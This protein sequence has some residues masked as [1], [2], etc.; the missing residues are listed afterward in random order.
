MKKQLIEG[1]TVE[2]LQCKIEYEGLEYFLLD[3]ID[4]DKIQCP[5]F[6]RDVYKFRAIHDNICDTLRN[7]G[8][9]I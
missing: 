6:K 3:Y 1:Y 5:D 9:D 2:D 4:A 8:V 7:E